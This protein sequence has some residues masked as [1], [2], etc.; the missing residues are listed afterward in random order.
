MGSSS[1]HSSISLAVILVFAV[2]LLNPDLGSC[3]CFK[4]IFSFGDSIT[5]TGNFAYISR[6]S[7]PGPPSVP[8]YGETYFHRPTGRASDGRLIIDFYG[9][10]VHACAHVCS[11]SSKL[12]RV[13]AE[14][15]A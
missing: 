14:F 6:N 2:L 4:R 13:H 15:G 1:R 8:P 5:D 3:G 9:E 11:N 7:P 12:I 10:Y